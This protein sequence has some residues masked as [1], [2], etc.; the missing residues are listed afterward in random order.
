MI[1]LVSVAFWLQ[2]RWFKHELMAAPAGMV[3]AAEEACP[4]PVS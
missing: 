1:G 4:P 2:R 3:A